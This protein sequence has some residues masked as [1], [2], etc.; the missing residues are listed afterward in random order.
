MVNERQILEIIAT[1]RIDM[2]ISSMSGKLKRKKKKLATELG[3]KKKFDGDRAYAQVE[4][5]DLMK[6]RGMRDGIDHFAEEFP[7]YGKILNGMIEEKRAK[8]ETHL[9]FG[10]YEGCRLTSD[11]YL[12]VMEN[13]GFKG[14]YAE[15]LYQQ[16]MNVSR[17][18]NKKRDEERSIMI[19]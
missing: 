13:L 14:Q 15:N 7:K 17:K 19:G 2:P 16:L 18:L 3:L 8:R 12:G 10:L 1:D 9:S 6:A 5:E 4:T 11:D